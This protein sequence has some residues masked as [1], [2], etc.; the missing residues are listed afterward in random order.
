M[1]LDKKLKKKLKP[2]AKKPKKK[3]PLTKQNSLKMSIVQKELPFYARA[4]QL[5]HLFIP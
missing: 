3:L 5:A 2:L 4:P 1:R